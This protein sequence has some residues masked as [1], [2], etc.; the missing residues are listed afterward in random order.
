MM[1]STMS[2][3]AGSLLALAGCG[4]D[5]AD[6]GGASASEALVL[7]LDNQVIRA[8]RLEPS[9]VRVDIFTRLGAEELAV[10]YRLRS[11]KKE[12]G[13][14]WTLYQKTEGGQSSLAAGSSSLPVSFS[15]LPSLQGAVQGALYMQ[16]AIVNGLYGTEY[17]DWGCDLLPGRYNWVASCGPKGACCDVHDACYAKHHCSAKS[18]TKP[19]SEHWQCAAVCNAGAVACFVATISPGP[20][21]CCARGNC[22]KPR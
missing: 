1:R 7:K 10:D 11:E 21:E 16:S 9:H 22:G 12:E 13:V 20:S 15:S 19:W 2:C 18:W 14:E 6:V 3:L 4:A 17:D 8:E 5:A